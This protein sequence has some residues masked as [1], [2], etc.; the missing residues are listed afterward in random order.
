M[1]ATPGD[2]GMSSSGLERAHAYV[3]GCVERSEI[4]GAVMLVARHDQVPQ[5]RL[6]GTRFWVDPV[7]DLSGIF[8]SLVCGATTS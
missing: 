2:L 4:A 3:E 1:P 6:L 7:N 8:W 5:G